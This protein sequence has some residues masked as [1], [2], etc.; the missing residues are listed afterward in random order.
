MPLHPHQSVVRDAWLT[1]QCIDNAR[2]LKQ[3][4]R[5]SDSLYWEVMA[6]FLLERDSHNRC[7]DL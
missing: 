5:L 7:D 2:D 1:Q 3:Q 4:G 6:R